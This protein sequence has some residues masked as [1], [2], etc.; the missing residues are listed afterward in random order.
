MKKLLATLIA[1]FLVTSAF[2]QSPAAPTAK[3]TGDAVM[4][5]GEGTKG[6]MKKTTP[7]AKTAKHMKHE[8]SHK[9]AEA[10]K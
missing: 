1:G 9:H 5:A 10:A 7:K 2:A 6:D 3:T 8:K 4:P